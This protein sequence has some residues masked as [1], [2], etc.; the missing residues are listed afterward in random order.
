MAFSHY[1][2]VLDSATIKQ[3]RSVSHNPGVNVAVAHGSGEANA[4]AVFQGQTEPSTSVQSTDLATLLALSTNT[5]IASGHTVTSAN[6][7]VQYRERADG[8]IY[9]SGASHTFLRCSATTLVT[10]DTISGTVGES[11]TCDFTMRY[12]GAAPGTAP[13]VS[14]VTAQTIASAATINGEYTLHS[15]SVAGSSITELQSVTIN[16]GI[17]V[18]NTPGVS[19]PQAYF[20]PEILPSIEIVTADSSAATALL[21]GATLGAG[22]VVYFAARASGG[23]ITSTASTAHVSVTGAAG[24]RQAP[25]IS[26]T[27]QGNG[28]ATIRITPLALTA[29]TGVAIS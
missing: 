8:G 13:P 2:V 11:A 6:C 23:I 22:C 18:I 12:H 25:T 7:D 29:A 10:P 5:F 20:M 9:A 21:E 4:A 1:D 15:V 24:M 14:E 17:S 28:T 16:P 3:I 27:D 26:T 19:F